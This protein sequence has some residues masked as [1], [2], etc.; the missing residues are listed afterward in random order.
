MKDSRRIGVVVSAFL[1]AALSAHVGVAAA[2]ETVSAVKS[3]DIDKNA[4]VQTGLASYYSGG[5]RTASGT[6]HE[7]GLTAAHRSLPFGTRLRVTDLRSGRDVIVT[8]NDRGPYRKKRIIDI[9]KKAAAELGILKRGIA[10][11]RI[12]RID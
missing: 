1:I 3:S 4:F 5:G 2:D 10:R 11:V 9:S 12:T 6:T 7:N 8:V